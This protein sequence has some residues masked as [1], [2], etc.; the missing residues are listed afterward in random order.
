MYEFALRQKLRFDTPVG[1]ITL[2]DLWD[3]PLTSTTNGASLDNI[4]VALHKQIENAGISFVVPSHK[5]KE[6]EVNQAKFDIVKHVIDVK[7]AEAKEASE[8]KD[9]KERK[10]KILAIMAD[11]DD[12]KLRN[13]SMSKLE[14]L[15]N[16][17]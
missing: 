16:D 12:A 6:R 10:Q 2:E 4:A 11:K 9:K 3:L 5:T 13:M 1:R 17:L 7:M 15:L 8:A 14:E